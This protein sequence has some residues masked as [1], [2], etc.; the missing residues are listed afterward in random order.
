MA[1]M[2]RALTLSLVVLFVSNLVGCGG[3]DRPPLG[4]VSGKVTIDGVPFTGVII[5]FMPGSGRPATAVTDDKGMY[6]LEYVDGV[7]GCKVGPANVSFFPPTGGS[8]S[9][10][11]PAKYTNNSTEFPVEIKSGAN[12]FDFD[13][14]SDGAAPQKKSPTGKKPVVLD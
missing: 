14:K 6:N 4:K 11:I 9:H 1:V 13:L 10:S 3:S 12:K 5:A 8:P 7:A 2:P